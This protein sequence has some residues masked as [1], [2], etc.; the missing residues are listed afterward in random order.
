MYGWQD[1]FIWALISLNVVLG[2]MALGFSFQIQ[3]IIG[4]LKHDANKNRRDQNR[5]QDS[6]Y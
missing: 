3:K 4:R 1:Y 5:G 6:R 2:L